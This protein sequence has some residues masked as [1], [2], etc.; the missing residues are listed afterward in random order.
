MR[1]AYGERNAS[2]K[3]TNR[4]VQAIRAAVRRGTVQK[5]LAGHFGVSLAVISRIVRGEG[6]THVPND[7]S[8]DLAGL[9]APRPRAIRRGVANNKAKLNP[10][11]VTEIRSR[12]AQGESQTALAKAFNVHQTT[13][14]PIVRGES[15]KES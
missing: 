8:V 3:L 15:W 14:S 7:P 10:Q 9:P 11:L 1:H 12:Y 6:W 2:A 4:D 13:I 5:D